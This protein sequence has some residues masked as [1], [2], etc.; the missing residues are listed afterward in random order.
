M[1]TRPFFVDIDLNQNQLEFAVLHTLGT[2]P[3]SGSEVEGQLYYDTGSNI[4]FFWNGSVWISMSSGAASNV[5]F[6]GITTSANT[7]ATMTVGTGAFLTFSGSG[8]INANQLV[9]FDI[10]ADAPTDSQVLVYQGGSIDAWQAVDSNTLGADLSLAII[11]TPLSPTRNTIQATA[12]Q[13][14][15][16]IL[17]GATGGGTQVIF[18]TQTDGA[19]DL[20]YLDND[21]GSYRSYFTSDLDF[22]SMDTSLQIKTGN[23]L[24]LYNSG[25]VDYVALMSAASITSSYSFTFPGDSGSS[26]EYL[27]NNGGS[28]T[29]WSTI[30]E[31]DISGFGTYFSTA[32]AGL[33]SSSNT[34]DVI[35][36]ANTG[37][38]VNADNITLDISNLD[39]ETIAGV[40]LIPFWDMTAT[41]TNKNMTFADF[42]AE[43][44]ILGTIATGVWEAT[45][46]AILHGGTGAS[47]A[48]IAINNLSGLS[49]QGDIL[50]R[51]ATNAIP[52]AIGGV[53]EY[54]KT[55]GTD[56]SWSTITESDISGFGTYFST[57]G[58]GLTSSSNTVDV[59]AG[60]NTGITVAADS[61]S[62][63]ISN[64]DTATIAGVDLIPF[65]DM[66]AT[67]T[68]KNMTFT[69]F[70]GQITILGTI[71]TGVWEATDVAILHGGTGASTAQS[72]INNLAGL[73]ARGDILVEDSS[74]DA[75]PL[76]LGADGTF[77]KAGAD[78]PSWAVITESDISGFGTY[79]S[80]GDTILAANGSAGSP[81]FSF[82]S[83]TDTGMYRFG[84]DAVSISGGGTIV[85]T[86]DGPSVTASFLGGV[87]IAGDLLVSGSTTT[88]N[89]TN[90]IVEDNFI[91]V[92]SM[93][94][95]QDAGIE[96]ERGNDGS[97]DNA[98]LRF[99]EI[100]NEWFVDNGSTSHLVARKHAEEITGDDAATTFNIDH[101]M[102]TLYVM[103][104]IFDSTT[105]KQ[106]EVDV[107]IINTTRVTLEFNV[108]PSGSDSYRIIVVG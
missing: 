16:T 30:T 1:G 63:D 96:V 87:S 83:D 102:G 70:Q 68:N 89:T 60:A 28:A 51:D 37:I 52:L 4:P 54:L 90:L 17:S 99:S 44:T 108:A 64:L 43:I 24:R 2:A 67:A 18:A 71:A 78:D 7:S 38:T 47:T 73:S 84:A 22:V 69:S 45:D 107:D 66:T 55:D 32:G 40:D 59:I 79:Y 74:S 41:A 98:Y 9:G 80:A 48:Q 39:T 33:T 27:K 62:L 21:S 65:W 46:V 106:V 31:S 76:A 15:L 19:S 14:G 6:S 92:N 50:T 95:V 20:F 88:I 81:S 42:Q 36:G 25:N 86:F 85:A 49:A 100:V 77:L 93:G 75:V 35:A 57:A 61:V 26:G 8:I 23:D 10:D 105:G 12:G 72:A 82:V 94:I 58:A 56:P 101:N 29:D 13:T 53:G 5:P 104:Q 11:L 103:V 97:G 3:S 91:I 34:V